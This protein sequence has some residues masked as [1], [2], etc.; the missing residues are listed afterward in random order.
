M[1]VLVF[2][3]IKNREITRTSWEALTAGHAIA[4]ATSLPVDVAIVANADNPI[5]EIGRAH[6]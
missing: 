6:V 2:L 4:E 1:S 5:L 3:E